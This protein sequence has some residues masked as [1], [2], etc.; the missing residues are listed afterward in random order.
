MKAQYLM[1]IIKNSDLAHCIAPFGFLISL[2]VGLIFGS[3]SYAQTTE[4]RVPEYIGSKICAGC[5]QQSYQ[6]WNKSHH[7]WALRMPDKENVLGDFNNIKFTHKDVTTRFT[8]RDGRYF[9][10]TLG[11]EGKTADFEVKYTIGVEPLQQ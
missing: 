8:T 9:I 6:A 3:H 10:E 2:L 7:S 4:I 5:H 1:K 11:S